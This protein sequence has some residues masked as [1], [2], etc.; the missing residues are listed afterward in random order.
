MGELRSR[1]ECVMFSSVVLHGR[2]T[3]LIVVVALVLLGAG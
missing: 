1:L 3:T 2:L